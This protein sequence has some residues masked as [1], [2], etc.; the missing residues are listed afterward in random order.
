MARKT[1]KEALETKEAIINSAKKLF[2]KNG[3]KNTTLNDIAI[4]IGQTRGAIYWHFNSKEEIFISI[5]D[6]FMYR[7]D[8]IIA[9]TIGKKDANI[10]SICEYMQ[11]SM[12]MLVND[13]EYRATLDLLLFRTELTPKL[14]ILKDRNNLWT[15]EILNIASTIIDKHLESGDFKTNLTSR[16]LAVS[17]VSMHRGLAFVYT[18]NNEILPSDNSYEAIIDAFFQNLWEADRD[19]I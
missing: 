11:K 5:Y 15:K 8:D 17:I 6:E 7:L 10:D 12:Y 4:D 13:Y 18:M 14:Q 9:K 2:Y 16:E 3:F 19:E 1:K